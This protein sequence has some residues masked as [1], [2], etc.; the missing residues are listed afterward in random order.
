MEIIYLKKRIITSL[1][2]LEWLSEKYTLPSVSNAAIR[3]KRGLSARSVIVQGDLVRHHIR[4]LYS[5][6]E[7]QD[8]SMLIILLPWDKNS[9]IFR[10][11]C[12]RSTRQ[13]S[14]LAWMGTFLTLRYLS[15]RL[16]LNIWQIAIRFICLS[17]YLN[18]LSYLI[19]TKPSR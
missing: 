5:V 16:F 4:R 6:S 19:L 8:S 13:R 18:T 11:Y 14:E 7:T 2:V 15:F 10:E 3:A 1:S 12:C 17:Y 9:S